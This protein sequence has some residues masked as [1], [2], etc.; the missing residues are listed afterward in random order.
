M[1]LKIEND[2]H[3]LQ[4]CSGQFSSQS[5]PS[6][7]EPVEQSRAKIRGD[8]SQKSDLEK[9][10]FFRDKTCFLHIRDGTK[11]VS[12]SFVFVRQR[13]K[14]KVCYSWILEMENEPTVFPYSAKA[15]ST[16]FSFTFN[17][18]LFIFVSYFGFT[19]NFILVITNSTFP[20]NPFI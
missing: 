14:Q 10:R 3:F 6:G 1:N 17:N 19:Q 5:A 9:N 7:S 13:D 2:L 20:Q 12:P 15:M 18:S 8:V 4:F 16:F 11:C